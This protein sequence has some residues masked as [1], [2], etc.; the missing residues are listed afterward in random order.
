[1]SRFDFISQVKVWANQMHS[2]GELITVQVKA[3][4]T[5]SPYSSQNY[6]KSMHSQA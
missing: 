4:T 5:I 2:L 6:F 1:M 3:I